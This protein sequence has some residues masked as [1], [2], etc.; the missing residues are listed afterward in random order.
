MHSDPWISV[1][2]VFPF[3]TA[4]HKAQNNTRSVAK[5]Y[6][7]KATYEAFLQSKLSII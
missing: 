3:S 5:T 4:D 1:V 7:D 6:S 2:Y